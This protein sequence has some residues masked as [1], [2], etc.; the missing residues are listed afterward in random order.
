MPLI[1]TQAAR[2]SHSRGGFMIL[3]LIA[4]T[5]IILGLATTFYMYCSRG[6]DD[7]QAAVRIAQQRISLNAALQYAMTRATLDPA[8]L[9]AFYPSSNDMNAIPLRLDTLNRTQRLG[10]FRI[11]KANTAYVGTMGLGAIISDTSRCVF[12]TAG[13]GPSG[14]KVTPTADIDW[15]YELRSWYLAEFNGGL[16]TIRK[17]VPVFPVPEEGGVRYW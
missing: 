4:F 5:S 3:M 17:I 16:P 1:Q 12:I 2:P 11:A 8:G 13:V 14:G 7:S 9:T 6:M 15:R 10:W